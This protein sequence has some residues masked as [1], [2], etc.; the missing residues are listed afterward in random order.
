MLLPGFLP[1]YFRGTGLVVEGAWKI[2]FWAG[3]IRVV[4]ELTGLFR[5]FNSTALGSG[6]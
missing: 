2:G 1:G 5:A 3:K 4:P 6:N